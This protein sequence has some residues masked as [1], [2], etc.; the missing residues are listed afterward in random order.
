MEATSADIYKGCTW[1]SQFWAYHG[2]QGATELGAQPQGSQGQQKATPL[3]GRGIQ[4]HQV[5]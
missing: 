3:A 5:P 1:G 2:P 4:P